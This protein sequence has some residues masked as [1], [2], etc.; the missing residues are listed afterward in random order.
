MK[1]PADDIRDSLAIAAALTNAA[2]LSI[3]D[4]PEEMLWVLSHQALTGVPPAAQRHRASSPSPRSAALTE[5]G[6]FVSRSE[7][8]DHLV[9]DGGPHGYQN[10]G[11]AHADALSMTFSI[12][13]VP[14]LIDP[15]TGCYTVDPAVRDRLRSTACHNTLELGGRS[16]SLPRG[17]FHW[18][19]TADT[20]VHR[21]RTAA[22]FDYF[23]GSHT[24]YLPAVHR[25]RVVS[26]HGEA[27]VVAD[28]VDGPGVHQIA[29]HWHLAPQ[30]TVAIEGRFATLSTTSV[31]VGLAVSGGRIERFVADDCNGLGWWSPAYGR[32][33]PTATLRVIA[34]GP[35]PQWI[36]SVFDLNPWDP[37]RGV[38]LVPLETETGSLAHGAGARIERVDSVDYVLF[39]EPRT[40]DAPGW[41]IAELATDAR[42]LIAR[43]TRSCRVA[44]LA[45]A[46]GSFVRQ[47]HPGGL[48]LEFGRCVPALRMDGATLDGR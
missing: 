22:G 46:D 29:L 18:Q 33:E 31:R 4:A 26:L 36:V 7:T 1:R 8:G 23:D 14:L 40:S 47:T 45:L 24:G 28:L 11:H 38:E 35:A 25:R 43:V 48:D 6:Y 42:L 21:W 37:V 30:W 20:R 9:I 19:R 34:S 32:L 27:L 10:G 2:E 17:P 15:G 44:H 39:A 3:G 16:Q 12:G 41:R 13:G 5:T